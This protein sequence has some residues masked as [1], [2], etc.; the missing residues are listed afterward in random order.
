LIL[1]IVDDDA[2]VRE[3]LRLLVADIAH[4]VHECED[5]GRALAA[6]ES[7]R[8]DWVLMDIEMPG[9]DGLLATRR[10]RAAD[11]DANV[12]IVTSHDDPALRE[13][14]ADAGARGLVLKDDLLA[15]RGRLLPGS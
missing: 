5:G 1:L 12:L 3:L 10:I 14:A 4:T 2:R 11:P 15:I 6:Y 7:C 8:P 9:G 13:A